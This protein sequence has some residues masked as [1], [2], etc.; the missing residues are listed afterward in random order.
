MEV[1]PGPRGEQQRLSRL[2]DEAVQMVLEIGKEERRDVD[3]PHARV[4]LRPDHASLDS[5][6]GAVDIDVLPA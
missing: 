4:G 5:Q 1:L 6:E 2:I 3:V